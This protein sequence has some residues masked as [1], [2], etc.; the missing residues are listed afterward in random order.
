[1]AYKNYL[2]LDVTG[3]NDWS[4]ALGVDNQSF[5]YPSV[6]TGFIFTDAFNIKSN[7][8]SYGKVRASWAQ[9]GNDSQTLYDT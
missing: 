8:L 3:R 5:F 2:F 1:M 4:S 7:I 6:S 9:S